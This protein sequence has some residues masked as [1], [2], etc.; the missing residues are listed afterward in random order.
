MSGPLQCWLD[1]YEQISDEVWAAVMKDAKTH[2]ETWFHFDGKTVTTI[3]RAARL[4]ASPKETA[5]T[6]NALEASDQAVGAVSSAPRVTLDDI[7]AAIAQ[8]FDVTALKAVEGQAIP[9]MAVVPLGLMSICILV[10]HN[11]WTIVGT[12][13]PASPENFNATIGM[14]LAYKDA[15]TKVWPLMGF[16][17]RERLHSQPAD[18]QGGAGPEQQ[19]KTPMRDSI[20]GVTG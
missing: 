10:L 8:R 3:G 20:T 13:A 11:G 1:E 18:P 15:I 17:L 7:K 12:S 19:S 4:A 9:S 2:G 6:M 16:A 14:D 5:M